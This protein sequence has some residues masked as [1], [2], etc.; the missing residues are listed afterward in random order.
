MGRRLS[1]LICGHLCAVGRYGKLQQTGGGEAGKLAS[2]TFLLSLWPS[3]W[4][5]RDRSPWLNPSETRILVSNLVSWS[6]ALGGSLSPLASLLLGR[7]SFLE[8]EVNLGS[9]LV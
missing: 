9:C 8:A 1:W 4:C 2:G 3:K 7:R 5:K 6:P